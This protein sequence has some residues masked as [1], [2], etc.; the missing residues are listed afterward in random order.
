MTLHEVEFDL[1]RAQAWMGIASHLRREGHEATPEQVLACAKEQYGLVHQVSRGRQALT[2]LQKEVAA[3]FSRTSLAERMRGVT[4]EAAIRALPSQ[5]TLIE[6]VLA[7]VGESPADPA[8]SAMR[9]DRELSL[10]AAPTERY[11]AIVAASRAPDRTRIFDLGPA[12]V[13][14]DLVEAFWSEGDVRQEVGVRLRELVFDP[15][16]E[17]VEHDNVIVSPDGALERVPFAALPDGDRHLLDA[18]CFSGIPSG[19]DFLRPLGARES[20]PSIVIANPDYDAKGGSSRTPALDALLDQMLGSD[21][22]PPG[23]SFEPLPETDAEGNEIARVI[24]AQAYL[25]ER[26]SKTVV[27]RSR[28]PRI[29]HLATHGYACDYRLRY[30]QTH[31]RV[32]ASVQHN[33]PPPLSENAELIDQLHTLPHPSLRSGLV[34]AG[35]NRWLRHGQVSPENGNGILTAEEVL[36]LELSGTELVTLSACETGLGDIQ[37]AE[38]VTGL[39]RAFLLAGA[40]A[41][42]V[43]MW[44]VP[45]LET[46]ELMI[47]FYGRLLAGE[48]RAQALRQSQLALRQRRPDSRWWGAFTLIGEREPFDPLSVTENAEPGPAP[49]SRSSD[50]KTER[51]PR[52]M[53]AAVGLGALSLATWG[54]L[55]S[56]HKTEPPP[57]PEPA[58][59]SVVEV[60]ATSATKPAAE[61]VPRARL[62]DGTNLELKPLPKE[63]AEPSPTARKR[64]VRWTGRECIYVEDPLFMRVR[65]TKATA[66]D[67][68]AKLKLAV[69]EDMGPQPWGKPTIEVSTA[70]LGATMK[71]DSLSARFVGW[72][73]SC[74]GASVARERSAAGRR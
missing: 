49:Q 35:V 23:A 43:S 25:R 30:A 63:V 46:K 54:A 18:Y 69:L 13:I 9:S 45:D 38:G 68:G 47:D 32:L 58:P 31:P 44:R 51:R 22:C 26:A 2:S 39:A 73:L 28:S 62:V 17:A 12:Q 48:S 20:G 19:R 57:A 59:A 6:F 8:D 61:S 55:S 21:G 70:W 53:L 24:G 52:L 50:P 34:L 14:N 67:W 56:T 33:P 64:I 15:L 16:R 3:R 10:R 72:N 40:R 11:V 41:V 5:C 4:S 60:P 7:N 1:W 65:V 27:L 66:D 74:D 71:G 37:R 42:L 36:V 29:L